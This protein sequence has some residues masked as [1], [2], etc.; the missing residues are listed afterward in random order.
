MDIEGPPCSEVVAKASLELV[1]LVV[2]I[3][4]MAYVY[5]FTSNYQPYQ[6]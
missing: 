5:V 6:R 2:L 1:G 3:L 4:P